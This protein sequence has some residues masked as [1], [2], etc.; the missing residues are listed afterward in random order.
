MEDTQ[1]L[2][3]INENRGFPHMLGSIV[4]YIGSRRTALLHDRGSIQGMLRV[5]RS[6]LRPL[7]AK[8]YGFG[9]LFL[10]W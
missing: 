3:S 8:I 2:L 1:R 5:A 7:L 4:V 10:V 6:Y 9:I